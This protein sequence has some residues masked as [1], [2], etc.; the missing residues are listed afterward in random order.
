MLARFT[1]C[2]LAAGASAY[3]ASPLAM[4]RPAL[5]ASVSP[6]MLQ[7]ETTAVERVSDLLANGAAVQEI[8]PVLYAQL[9]VSA[10]MIGGGYALDAFVDVPEPEEFETP[11]GETD[12]YRDSPLRFL[13]YANEVGE[14]FRPLVPVEVVYFSYF[15]AISYIL[16]DTVDKG[17]QGAKNGALS[18]VMGA[19]D[20]FSWQMLASV[21][22]PSFIINRFVCY[23]ASANAAG[24]LPEMLQLDWL[25]T[26]A[27]L[28]TI[29][30][31]IVPLDIL[32]HFSMNGS[33]RK[34]GAL[35]K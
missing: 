33:F 13:G 16:A 29:P 9:S 20:T 25:P 4:S 23:L 28:I 34:A 35:L 27:G 12:I 8:G 11:E 32:A 3:S 14:A 15:A 26:A 1:V 5:R 22:F 24:T 2:T 7:A 18:G 10:A 31:I 6:A 21:L 19:V 17:R 30:L